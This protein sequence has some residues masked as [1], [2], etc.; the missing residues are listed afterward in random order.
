MSSVGRLHPADARTFLQNLLR[1][2][3]APVPRAQPGPLRRDCDTVVAASVLCGAVSANFPNFVCDFDDHYY[4]PQ[5]YVDC[6]DYSDYDEP[7][8]LD[9]Y[10]DVYGGVD[11][12]NYYAP[13]DIECMHELHGPDKCGVYC[14]L[15]YEI[16]PYGHYA[17]KDG[18]RSH[19]M[20]DP[21]KYDHG[22]GKISPESGSLMAMSDFVNDINPGRKG[23]LLPSDINLDMPDFAD[24]DN[25]SQVPECVSFGEPGSG[26]ISPES[27]NVMAMSDFAGDIDAEPGAPFLPS[28]VHLDMPNFADI[29][30]VS[31]V[32]YYVSFGEPRSGT[33]SPE[34][35]N[36][37]AMSDFAGDIGPEP[38]G[39]F[40]PSG[41]Q[42]DMP[43]FTDVDSVSR[44]PDCVDFGEPRSGTVSPGSGGVV[45][46]SDFAGDIDPGPSEP[47]L[48]SGVHLDMPGFADIDNVSRVPDCVS[49][50]EPGSGT[51]SP[52]SGV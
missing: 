5:C 17:P 33:I 14:Q 31:H 42:L 38:G 44:V 46:M 49:F 16:R 9:C 3:P 47:L 11:P 2:S 41:V 23:P 50:G 25:V 22:P 7:D 30:N 26:T 36:V 35:G 13:T 48:P 18:E 37:M 21:A 43:N 1:V 52:E 8:E 40:L 51:I 32:P 12:A 27:G 29:D 15:Q 39:P 4:G 34:S 45:A 6:S 24:I 28:G 20:N 19:G 10:S